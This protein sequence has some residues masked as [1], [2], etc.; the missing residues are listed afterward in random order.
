MAGGPTDDAAMDRIIVMRANG[1]T[2]PADRAKDIQ[3]G[4][5]IVVPSEHMFRAKR[6]GGGWTET[7]RS[8]L[9]IAAAALAF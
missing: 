7:L 5:V 6:V 8:L 1:A 9:S 2:L 4:D 3:P